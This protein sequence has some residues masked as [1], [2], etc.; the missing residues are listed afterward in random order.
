MF[1][2][3]NI[4]SLLVGTGCLF[5]GVGI[6]YVLAR[7]R[8]TTRATSR[9]VE[10]LPT[11][12]P[13]ADEISQLPLMLRELSE[14]L[15]PSPAIQ[16]QLAD[17]VRLVQKQALDIERI[18]RDSRTDSLTGLWNRRALDEQ[19]PLLLSASQRYGTAL[20]V[21]MVDIDHFKQLNDQYGHAAGDAALVHIAHLLR[22]SLRDADFVARYGG[23]EFVMLLIQTDLSGA[24]VA[25]E[26]IRKL[27][28]ESPFRAGD[29]AMVVK[30][31][32]GLAQARRDD[33]IAD[34]LARAD[35]ALRQAKQAGRNQIRTELGD[36]PT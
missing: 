24:L 30:V 22:G 2:P 20:S 14:K 28:L 8:F 9:P 15:D 13:A 12:F 4:V 19:V 25:T 1:V 27:I 17:I 21:I 18:V 6:G 29:Q 36:C 16:D 34:V 11:T 23:E 5:A 7:R 26:R 10:K 31:S 3:A 33:Q 32:M 35:A